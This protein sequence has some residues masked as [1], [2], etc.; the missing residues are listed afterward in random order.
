MVLYFSGTGN[1]LAVARQLAERLNE[2]LMPLMA[3]EAQDLSNEKRIGLVFPTYDFNLPPVVRELVPQLNISPKSYVFAI[4]TCGGQAGNCVWALRHILRNKGIELAYSHKVRVPD[5]SALAFG[6]N[7]NLQMKKFE[8]VPERMEQIISEVQ[9]ESHALHY[10]WFSCLSWLLGLPTVE[11]GMIR[12]LGPKVNTGKCIGC[13][14]C[15]RVCPMENISLTDKKA[16]IGNNCTVCLACVH[17]CPQ[18]AISTNGREALK[19]R[20]YRH[21]QVKLK[22]LLLR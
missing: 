12:T 17:V 2:Q 1:S 4:V 19:E 20:Q 7:P 6:R 8:H 15:V 13:N 22:D 11:K 5:N 14:T 21:P 10:S 9:A 16:L 3:A 18:Q